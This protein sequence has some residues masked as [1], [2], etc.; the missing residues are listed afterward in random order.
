MRCPDLQNGGD[1]QF[2]FLYNSDFLYDASLIT[3]TYGYINMATG[4]WPYT[5]DYLSIQVWPM[6]YDVY[7]LI[8]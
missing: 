2:G 6:H 8:H 1:E 5:F 4:L 7:Y 3:D